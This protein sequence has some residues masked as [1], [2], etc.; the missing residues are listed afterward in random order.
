MRCFLIALGLVAVVGCATQPVVTPHQYLDEETAA[1]VTVV[2]EPWIFS[3]KRPDGP[4]LPTVMEDRSPETTG[5]AREKSEFAA[6]RRDLISLYAIDVNRMGDHRQYLAVQQSLPR[7]NG[8][9]SVPTLELRSG[10]QLLALKPV[11][12]TPRELGIAQ[13]PVKANGRGSQWSY[14]AIDK[15]VLAT[16]ARTHDLQATLIVDGDRI[17]YD[18]WR[19]GSAELSRLSQ[20]VD[21]GVPQGEQ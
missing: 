10:D 8:N 16:V 6:D 4:A 9:A 18:M 21:G 11:T 17:A 14:F 15:E 13:S 20:E 12:Q 7:A 1:T 2:S 3:T 19:D 5:T